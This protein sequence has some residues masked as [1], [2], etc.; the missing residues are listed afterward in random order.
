MRGIVTHLS[1]GPWQCDPQVGANTDML[2]V[3]GCSPRRATSG[4]RGRKIPRRLGSGADQL[5]ADNGTPCVVMDGKQRF[6]HEFTKLEIHH[7]RVAPPGVCI[8]LGGSGGAGPRFGVSVCL[9]LGTMPTRDG[10]G[11]FC[12]ARASLCKSLSGERVGSVTT[13]ESGAVMGALPALLASDVARDD[14]L[15]FSLSL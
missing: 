9:S 3:G 5:C 4:R 10:A 2:S 14:D 1:S 7:I 12:F 13:R 11:S 15:S 6:I 8:R